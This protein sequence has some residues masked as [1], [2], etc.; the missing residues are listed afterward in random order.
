GDESEVAA[1]VVEIVVAS[2]RL[3]DER[4]RG[5]DDDD[6]E[7]D[8]RGLSESHERE[9]ALGRLGDFSL[10]GHFPALSIRDKGRD[11][12]SMSAGSR[13]VCPCKSREPSRLRDGACTS[14]LPSSTKRFAALPANLSDNRRGEASDG[15]IVLSSAAD[16][17]QHK[18]RRAAGAVPPV[19]LRDR[20]DIRQRAGIPLVFASKARRR[21]GREA[22]LWGIDPLLTA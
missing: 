16:V 22:M 18:K 8:G 3:R 13:G 19:R 9:A 2:E 4:H 10:R 5:A 11:D 17:P 20:P 6:G 7:R 1:V 12:R 21:D 14:A 15:A